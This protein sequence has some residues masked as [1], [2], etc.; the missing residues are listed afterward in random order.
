MLGLTAREEAMSALLWAG[1]IVGAV[2][3][4][5][6][7]TY[8]YNRVCREAPKVNPRGTV[9]PKA[10]SYAI[11]TMALWVLFGVYVTV[12]WVIACCFYIPSRL[13]GRQSTILPSRAEPTSGAIDLGEAPDPVSANTSPTTR[14]VGQS[15]FS[16]I[17]RVAIV[18]AGASGLAA[19]RILLAQGLD[20]TLFERR[21]ALG[22][23]WADGYLNFGVQV[24]RE[25]YEF[26]DWPLPADTANFTPG[27]AFEEYLTGYA[28]HFG[29][30][31]HIRFGCTVVALNERTEPDAG[32]RVSY[33][34]N[35]GDKVEDFDLAVV[36]VGLYSETPNIPVFDG[37]NQFRG[38]VIHVSALKSHDQLTGKRVVVVGYG[39]SA[40]DAAIESAAV[41]T[42]THLVLRH[43]HWPVPRNLLG[44][45]PF[46]W[47]MLNRLTSTLIPMYLHP[48]SLERWVQTL[49]R[50]LIWF[51]WRLVELLLRFQCRLGSKFGTREN[52]V[53][54]EPVEIGS[55]GE[56]TMLPRPEFYRLIRRG[57]IQARRA[58]VRGFAP[59]EVVL[60]SGDK[61]AADLVVLA[62][63]WKTDYAFLPEPVRARLHLE[64]DGLYLYRH[65]LHPDLP[66]L[67]FIGNASTISS[68]LTYSLQARW[69]GD[70]LAGK[71][72][73]PN[74]DSMR[75]EIK[76]LREWKRRWMPPSPQRGARLILH[77]LHY[78]DELV[79]DVGASEL[80]K[81]G[82]FAPL[83]ELIAPYQPRDYRGVVAGEESTFAVAT[84]SAAAVP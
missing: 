44:I 18:G 64:A 76:A 47:G 78:H 51:W 52:L 38:E 26:P 45:L 12:L 74:P 23:V 82:F 39:K 53:P 43:A 77:M 63:G 20:C 42:S 62:T 41:A 31:P 37:S 69:L 68:V 10:I 66:R 6:H 58:G 34:D 25:L 40:T 67:A 8:V 1:T 30:L 4:L 60:E 3:G 72:V 36:T 75:R 7:G 81:L 83:K 21:P 80:R 70:L 50:P 46:K 65:I 5:G 84:V 55:F 33:R 79:R 48:T 35:S 32:W 49:G 9:R 13:S 54:D 14:G 71:F 2:C 15:A 16:S 28:R 29:V 11:W 59:S 73:L 24:Q 19:A 56:P 27:P 17:R 22:G 61:I 57:V